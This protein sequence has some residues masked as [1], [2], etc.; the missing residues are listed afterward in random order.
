MKKVFFFLI[1]IYLYSNVYSQTTSDDFAANQNLITYV[2][3]L[4]SFCGI[5]S[6]NLSKEE[7]EELQLFLKNENNLASNTED[8]LEL[9]RAKFKLNNPEILMSYLQTLKTSLSAFQQNFGNLNSLNTDS[10]TIGIA[11]ISS[12][13]AGGGF[14]S[15]EIGSG[16]D[17]E[18]PWRFRLCCAAAYFEGGIALSACLS[19]IGATAGVATP[20]SIACA[21]ASITWMFNKALE[22]KKTWCT[23]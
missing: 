7:L 12:D 9:L 13:H 14:V 2:N 19:A 16:G 8:E 15:G 6:N 3:T 21:A 1:A 4:N 18:N 23:P 10:L 22:C 5:L 11:K 17:C 20:A